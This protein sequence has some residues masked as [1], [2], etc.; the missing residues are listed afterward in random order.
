MMRAT[1]GLTLLAVLLLAPPS[2]AQHRSLA[3]S[4]DAQ[5]NLLQARAKAPDQASQKVSLPPFLTSAKPFPPGP[6]RLLFDM[7]GADNAEC[8]RATPDVNGDGRDE[9]LVG[10]GKSGVDNVFCLDGASQGTADIVWSLQTNGGLSGGSCWGDQSLVPVSDTESNAHANVLVGTAWGGRTAYNLD[11]L[12]GNEVWRFDTYLDV[13]SGWVYSLSEISDVTADGVPEV[14]IGIGSFGDAVVLIDG[15]STGP[16]ATIVW[17]FDAGDAVFSVRNLGDTNGD[18]SD[19]VLAAVGEDVDRIVCLEGDSSSPGGNV[20]WSY[21]PG[22]S[23]YACGVLSDINSD[24]VDEAI[25]V[26]WTSDGSAIRC[27]NGVDGALLWSSTTV[28]AYGMA[29]DELQDLTGDGVNEVIVSSW[30]N[31]VT[32]LDG[33]DGSLVWR[34]KVGTLNGGDVWT[35]RSIGDLNG[36][37]VEDVVA[38]SFDYHVYALE[39]RT[40]RILWAYDTGNRVFSVYPV[41]D[42][43]GDGRPDVVAG[44]QDTTSNVVVHVLDGDGL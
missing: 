38:G 26:L 15:A 7:V 11:T 27:L 35:A 44:T 13:A 22:I 43:N 42:L 4:V 25:A 9:I 23:V 24:G 28:A 16:Q 17:R 10:I 2:P 34:Q 40:G 12:A 20:L 30:E 1:P 29:V 3:K 31:A 33:A 14:A 19:D 32:V 39:G 8:V 5:R 6:G 18:G 21:Q 36:D 41:G 37:G